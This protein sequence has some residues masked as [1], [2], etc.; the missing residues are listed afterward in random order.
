MIKGLCLFELFKNL[1]LFSLSIN[2]YV[3]WSIKWPKVV[4][5]VSFFPKPM[6]MSSNVVLC[7]RPKHI[8]FIV[9]DERKQKI[10]MKSEN[11]DALSFQNYYWMINVIVDN[12]LSNLCSPKER[13]FTN[14]NSYDAFKCLVLSNQQ[15][16]KHKTSS[17]RKRPNSF[18]GK[19]WGN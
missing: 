14:Y 13:S 2:R 16:L 19:S 18:R 6:M 10:F 7:T 1:R 17:F 4:K 15:K 12:S 11:L 8:Q 3:V 5:H 9:T